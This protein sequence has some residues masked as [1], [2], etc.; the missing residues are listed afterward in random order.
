[1]SLAILLFDNPN[2]FD[3]IF[4]TDVSFWDRTLALPILI[5]KVAI[6]I[7]KDTSVYSFHKNNF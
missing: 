1:M 5:R 6:T 2:N 4:I 7:Q 3:H